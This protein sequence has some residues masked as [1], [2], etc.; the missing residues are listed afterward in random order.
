MYNLI[1]EGNHMV[2]TINANF[3][4]VQNKWA[5]NPVKQRGRFFGGGGGAKKRHLYK[6]PR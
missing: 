5:I 1:I 4:T 2:E 6:E 3:R